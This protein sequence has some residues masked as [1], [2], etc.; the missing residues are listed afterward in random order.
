MVSAPTRFGL[1]VLAPTMMRFVNTWDD[2]MSSPTKKEYNVNVMCRGGH[3]VRPR[4]DRMSS[5]TKKEY[6]YEIRKNCHCRS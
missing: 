6:I 2:R 5:P 1:A 4:D 3:F